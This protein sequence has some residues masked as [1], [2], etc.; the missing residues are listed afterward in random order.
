MKV[1]GRGQHTSS[2]DKWV[3]DRIKCWRTDDMVMGMSGVVRKR[4]TMIAVE[5]PYLVGED[6]GWVR[7]CDVMK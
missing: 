7:E 2:E 3:G 5:V 6:I 4:F 1:E